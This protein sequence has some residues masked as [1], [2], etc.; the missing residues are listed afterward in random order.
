MPGFRFVTHPG[1]LAQRLV[2]GAKDWPSLAILDVE[3][4]G[5]LTLFPTA[6]GDLPAPLTGEVIRFRSLAEVEGFLGLQ[7][8]DLAA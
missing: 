2:Y 8:E 5:T 7:R 1:L 6:W 3:S 4:D